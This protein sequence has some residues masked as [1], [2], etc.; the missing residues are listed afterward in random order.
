MYHA[1][2]TIVSYWTHPRNLKPLATW[3]WRVTIHI[4]IYIYMCYHIYIYKHVYI[5]I[6]IYIYVYIYTCCKLC[7]WMISL[8]FNIAAV[9]ASTRW[10]RLVMRVDSQFLYHCMQRSQQCCPC[11]QTRVPRRPLALPSP[12]QKRQKHT[13]AVPD[14]HDLGGTT[15]L[16]LLV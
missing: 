11:R 3:D 10:V 6:Y 13:D 14:Q 7:A 4:Y 16:T 2:V 15:C 1:I 12:R 5:H 8:Q 9:Y